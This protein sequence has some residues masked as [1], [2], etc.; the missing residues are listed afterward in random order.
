[1]C[2]PN[3]TGAVAVLCSFIC[4][5][6]VLLVKHKHTTTS[7][8]VIAAYFVLVARDY[9]PPEDAHCDLPVFPV[10][11]YMS[12]FVLLDTYHNHLL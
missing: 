5:L 3:I 12:I 8:N 7:N 9:T 1:M 4:R 2:C 6:N 10:C 11:E